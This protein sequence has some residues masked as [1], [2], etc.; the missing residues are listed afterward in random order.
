ME[1]GKEFTENAKELILPNDY[2]DP[3]EILPESPCR[4]TRYDAFQM[5]KHAIACYTACVSESANKINKLT[6]LN[7]TW[8]IKHPEKLEEKHRLRYIKEEECELAEF[9]QFKQL[10]EPVKA[11]FANKGVDFDIV[12]C[13][14]DD[15]ISL[16]D[17]SKVE[18]DY[19]SRY[20][21]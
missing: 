4:M 12:F 5:F 13:K 20:E 7:C 10:M 3:D 6:L 17:K 1:A 16:M 11:L 15:F 21:L 9:T 19:L 8:A 18:L 14:W 2:D